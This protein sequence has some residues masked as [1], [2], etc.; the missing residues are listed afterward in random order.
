MDHSTKEAALVIK[1][2]DDIPDNFTGIINIYDQYHWFLNGIYYR[3]NGPAI[4]YYSGVKLWFLNGNG[5]FA[6]AMV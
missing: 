5:L 1:D 2:W 3:K 4:V 6:R